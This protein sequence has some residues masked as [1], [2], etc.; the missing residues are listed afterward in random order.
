MSD[1]IKMLLRGKNVV[2]T[3][4]NRGIGFETLRLLAENGANI[5]ACVRKPDDK[6]LNSIQSLSKREG[7][8]IQPI[9][10]DLSVLEQVKVGANTILAEKKPVDVLINNAGSIFTGSIHMTSMKKLDEILM[11]NFKSQIYF[12][13]YISRNMMRN[14]AGSIINIASS[15]GIEGNEGRLAYA[16][17]KSAV[18]TASKVMANEFGRFGIRVNSIA[19]GLTMTEMMQTSTSED[20]ICDVLKRTAMK[21]IGLPEEIGQVAIFLASDLASFI[22]GQVLRVDGGM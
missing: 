7:V 10:F 12:T 14:K 13:Q 9:Y 4:C 2:L 1:R 22:T 18:I 8:I 21:R 15:A 17:S 16:A 5:W 19:P 20:A 11:I 3:G 6:F